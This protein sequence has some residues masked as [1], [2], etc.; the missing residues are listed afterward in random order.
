[1]ETQK[2]CPYCKKC[3]DCGRI[4]TMNK[5]NEKAVDF[6]PPEDFFRVCGY[7]GGVLRS[8]TKGHMYVNVEKRVYNCKRCDASGKLDPD[9]ILKKYKSYKRTKAQTKDIDLFNFDIVT[10]E[11]KSVFAYALTRLPKS[12]VRKY[13]RWSPQLLG[14]LIFPIYYKELLGYS[15]RTILAEGRRPK[16]L[17]SGPKSKMVYRFDEVEDWA[18]ITEGTIDALST[19]HGV[20]AFGKSV[21]EFQIKLLS[22][23]YNTLYIALDADA[24]RTA[25][26]LETKLKKMRVKVYRLQLPEGEDPNSLGYEQMKKLIEEASSEGL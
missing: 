10:R 14:R 4:A 26:K 15:A 13:C 21:S 17:T 5:A 19:P 24:E 20:C 25:K 8:D 16:Y 23:K 6:K 1:M 12:I 2:N 7:C 3:K 18:V 9:E 22:S 11:A